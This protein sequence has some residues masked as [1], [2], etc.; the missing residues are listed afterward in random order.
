MLERSLELLLSYWATSEDSESNKNK[1]DTR[2]FQLE[3]DNCW[4]E[5]KKQLIIVF[6]RRKDPLRLRMFHDQ[7]LR[8]T[9]L[10]KTYVVDVLIPR[11]QDRNQE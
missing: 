2:L 9:D 5:L 6:A 10:C 11:R 8:Y 4:V 3:Q 1:S 7:S